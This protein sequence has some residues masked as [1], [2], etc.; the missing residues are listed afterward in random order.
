MPQDE[1]LADIAK[2]LAHLLTQRRRCMLTRYG[3]IAVEQ[4]TLW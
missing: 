2:A 1:C 4:I 3:R